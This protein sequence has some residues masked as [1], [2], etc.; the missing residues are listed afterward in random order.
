VKWFRRRR[1]EQ[2]KPTFV[3]TEKGRGEPC[4]CEPEWPE[5]E[6]EANGHRLPAIASDQLSPITAGVLGELEARCAKCHA[7]YPGNWL[8]APG[9]PPPFAWARDD[10]A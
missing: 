6:T 5:L 1:P 3:Q 2:P 9:T 10:D 4:R 7:T 8:L